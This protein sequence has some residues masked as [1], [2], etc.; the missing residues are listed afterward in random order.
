MTFPMRPNLN[1]WTQWASSPVARAFQIALSIGRNSL[2]VATDRGRIIQFFPV[3]DKIIATPLRRFGNLKQDPKMSL[4][5]RF[6]RASQRFL[7]ASS[8]G[9]V[10]A[11][12]TTAHNRAWKESLSDQAI[13]RIAL[14]PRANFL[15]AE[16]AD[17]QNA[18]GL[19]CKRAPRC[20]FLSTMG[21]SLV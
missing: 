18:F 17:P 3:R 2:L 15:L 16:T 6:R 14:A 4:R 21:Q 11:F 1:C 9:S 10:A 12:N 13:L 8:D 20:V 7:T 5:W 19:R